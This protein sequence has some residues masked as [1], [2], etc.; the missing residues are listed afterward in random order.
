MNDNKQKQPDWLRALTVMGRIMIS[1]P[2]LLFLVQIINSWA[3]GS[4]SLADAASSGA[5]STFFCGV[6]VLVYVAFKRFR[7]G[8]RGEDTGDG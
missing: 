8:L 3:G 5:G 4:P 7:Q 1:V 6:V 2:I